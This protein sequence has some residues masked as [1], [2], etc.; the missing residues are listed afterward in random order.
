MLSSSLQGWLAKKR[1]HPSLRDSI[2]SNSF[3]GSE[4]PGY[5]QQSLRDAQR[6]SHFAYS[7][8]AWSVSEIVLEPYEGSSL[9]LVVN[10]EV[11]TTIGTT[12][13]RVEQSTLICHCIWR[14]Q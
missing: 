2:N 8:L 4:L 13:I 10:Q 9:G 7:R 6:G 3:P 1:I 12:M 11:M 5:C 14:P